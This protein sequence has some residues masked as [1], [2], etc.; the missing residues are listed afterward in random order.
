MTDKQRKAIEYARI[1]LACTWARQ[2]PTQ[3]DARFAALEAR[4][5]LEAAFDIDPDGNVL[6]A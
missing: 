6:D 4:M 2:Y 3:D 1:V 5:K